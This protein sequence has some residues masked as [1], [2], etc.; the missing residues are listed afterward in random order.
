MVVSLSKRTSFSMC[1]QS[2]AFVCVPVHWFGRTLICPGDE[3]CP[4]CAVGRKKCY[5]YTVA[6]VSKY[7]S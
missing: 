1:I 7:P 2:P 4:A 3:I 6:T 5:W